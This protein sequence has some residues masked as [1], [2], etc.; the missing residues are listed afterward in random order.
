MNVNFEKLDNVHGMLTVTLEEKDYADKIKKQLK[1]ISRQRPE[2]GF[3]PGHTPEGLLR[4]KY[5]DA[6]KYDVI[7]QAVGEAVY[8]YIRENDLHVLGNPMP[9]AENKFDIKD[10]DFTMK[11]KIGVAPE[12]NT[13]L[14]KDL[15]IPFYTIKVADEMIDR[16]DKALCR[17]F[18]KQEPG[19]TTD[20]TALV[21]GVLT[22]LNEDGSVKEGGI[23]VENG[24]LSVEYIADADQKKLFE[25][26]HPGDTVR[27]NPA[28]T[29]NANPAELSSM[30]NIDKAEADAHHGDFNMEIKEI[31][32][33]KPAEHNQEFFDSVFG[34][35]KVH[36]EEEYRKQLADMIALQLTA[37]SNYRFTI[38]AKDA[39]VKAQGEMELPDDV[40]KAFL[41]QQNEALNDENIEEEYA[42][43]RP[44]LEWELL[45]E[46]IASQL[47]V[48]VSEEELKESARRFT[49]QQLM[50]YGMGQ[51]PEEMIDKYAENFLK[52]E[53]IRE[54]IYNFTVDSKLYAGIKEAATID[55]KDVDVEE[56]NA[57]FALPE[58]ETAAE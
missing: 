40:L 9:E 53:K 41:K 39:L 20:E 31:I 44:Q 54:Q 10:T 49:A 21:K 22:E 3:R 23:V 12:I 43:A 11:F 48:T 7:N 1:E 33:L 47:D 55:N 16:Q 45:R 25:E 2:P 4:K 42:K 5:G 8:D 56:F 57:L 15:H 17:R 32:V 34:A 18:G 37:D 36:N 24:I 35:D 50:Q 28:A 38:D 19:E 14:D 27:F 52:D 58:A 51:M 13:H 26:K 46:A 6:V 29:C 30:L